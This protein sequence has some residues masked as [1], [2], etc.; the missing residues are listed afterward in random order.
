MVART[1]LQNKRVWSVVVVLLRNGGVLPRLLRAVAVQFPTKVVLVASQPSDDWACGAMPGHSDDA[2][3]ATLLS[4][5]SQPVVS[6]AP[7]FPTPPPPPPPPQTHLCNPTCRR[8]TFRERG[9]PEHQCPPSEA[10]YHLLIC[11]D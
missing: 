8:A 4:I 1:P 2:P 7:V 6:V 3:A 10:L 11:T 5:S 9:A